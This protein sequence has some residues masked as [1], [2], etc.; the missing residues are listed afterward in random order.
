MDGI[1]GTYESK[2]TAKAIPTPCCS[3]KH[4]SGTFPTSSAA[5]QSTLYSQ[6]PAI[7]WV[8]W[9]QG[10][11][12]TKPSSPGE[13]DAAVSAAAGARAHTLALNHCS[14]VH[15]PPWQAAWKMPALT[16]TVSKEDSFHNLKQSRSGCHSGWGP[17]PTSRSA[18]S[19]WW[20]RAATPWSEPGRRLPC[21]C[22]A[23]L[24]YLW[25]LFLQKE[26]SSQLKN[27]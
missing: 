16:D 11:C 4:T 10:W 6:A 20:Q 3:S 15:S 24:C 21:K 22:F 5:E 23:H 27:K 7:M 1:E 17:A 19:S 8:L 26:K 9:S 14:T 12:V 25:W 2:C 13:Q 18:G